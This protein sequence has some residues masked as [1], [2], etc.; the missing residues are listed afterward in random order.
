MKSAGAS[1]MIRSAAILALFALC[2]AGKAPAQAPSSAVVVQPLD[3]GQILPGLTETVTV[4]D[5]WRRAEVQLEGAGSLDVKLVLP[6]ALVSSSGARIPLVF[7][8]GD[9][10]VEYK[11][12]RSAPFDPALP[13]RIHI[14]PGHAQA[15]LVVGGSAATGP[16]QVAGEYNATIVVVISRTD[17]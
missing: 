10:A 4:L 12:G 13:Q 9:A 7:R 2:G 11:N 8:N 6:D 15:T 5:A 16:G 3:F 14:P 17:A 1:R